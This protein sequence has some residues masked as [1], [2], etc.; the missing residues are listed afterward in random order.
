MF[1]MDIQTW[2]L[3][4]LG[5]DLLVAL[6]I[7]EW[8]RAIGSRTIGS[9]YSSSLLPSTGDQ[10][11]AC[12]AQLSIGVMAANMLLSDPPRRPLLA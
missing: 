12:V 1:L 7:V 4:S 5:L 6:C 3:A 8:L 11:D 2:W 10:L 9:E